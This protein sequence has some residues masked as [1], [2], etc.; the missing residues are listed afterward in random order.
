MTNEYRRKYWKDYYLKNKDR[1]KINAKR[2]RLKVTYNLTE[3]QYQQMFLDQDNKCA[4]CNKE[5]KLHVDHCP[6]T[7]DVRGLLCF[8]CNRGLGS[9]NDN[10]ELV[11]SAA[12]Y[13]NNPPYVVSPST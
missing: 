1:R 12:A 10:E 3:A 13:L 4:I 5:E 6:T 9:F 2:S 8:G 7:G 11:R